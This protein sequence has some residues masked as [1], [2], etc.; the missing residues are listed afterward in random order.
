D[1]YLLAIENIPGWWVF[2]DS[3]RPFIEST[4]TDLETRNPGLEVRTHWITKSSFGRN[5]VYRPY[6]NETSDSLATIPNAYFYPGR[7]PSGSASSYYYVP[8]NIHGRMSRD[9]VETGGWDANSNPHPYA[10]CDFFNHAMRLP[11]EQEL[12]QAR[13]DAITAREQEIATAIAAGTPVPDPLDD[14]SKEPT[15]RLFLE[16]LNNN[17]DKY[18]NALVINLHGE[19]LPMP[20]LRNYSDA[21]RDPAVMPEVRVVSHPEQLHTFRDPSGTATEAAAFRVYAYNTDTDNYSGSS[22]VP[23]IAIDVMGMDVTDPTTPALDVRSD[24]RLE[25]LRGGISVGGD[26][27]YYPFAQA[28]VYGDPTLEPGEMCYAAVPMS[29]SAFVNGEVFT[30]IFLFNTPCVAPYVS[31]RGLRNTERSQLYGMSY[32]PSPCGSGGDFSRDLYSTGSAPKNTARWRLEL[33]ATSFQDALFMNQ[34]GQYYT[35][36][37]YVLQLRTRIWTSTDAENSGTMWPPAQRN[38]PENLSRTYTWWVDSPNDVP[39]TERSQFFGDPRHMPYLDLQDGDPD[40]PNGYNWYWDSLANGGEDAVGDFPGLNS[41]NTR[42]GWLGRVTF[43]A[44]RMLKLVRDGLVKSRCVYTTLT[45][46]SY[47]YLGV[48]AEIGYDAANGYPNS[49][50]VDQTPYGSSGSGFVNNITGPRTMPRG[51]NGGSDFWWAMPWLGE[52]SPDS[53]Y[54]THWLATDSTGAVMGNLPAGSSGSE[55]RHEVTETI[56][57]ASSR[58]AYGTRLPQTLHRLRE[59]GC[60]SLFNTGTQSSTFHHQYSS[61]IG[62]LTQTGQEIASNYNFNMPDLTPISRPFGMNTSGSG[63]VGSEWS[64]APY[65]NER[66]ITNLLRQYY[67]HP[68]GNNGS[69][70]V[71]LTDPGDTRSSFIVV[72][73]IDRTVQTGSSFIAKFA[74]LSLVHS[75]FEG[76]GSAAR[77]RIKQPARIEITSPTDITELVSPAQIDVTVNVEWTRWD[78]LPYTTNGGLAEDETELEYVLLYSRDGGATWLH[79]RDDSPATPGQRPTNPFLIEPD[80][81]S[82]PETF[83]WNSPASSYPQG[84]YYLRV[85]CFRSG[86]QIHYSYHKT[87]LF[88]QR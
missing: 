19:L 16:D 51:N 14:M 7:M 45:G 8:Q 10:L 20:A 81:G 87:K 71:E 52:L 32:I 49:I 28:K 44:P 6:T 60:T 64:L 27:S 62:A 83:S 74:V 2:M 70:L 25:N 66:S 29:F 85:D 18:S 4:I 22:T 73:G 13:V 67:D 38:A 43:D 1:L 50:P 39:V 57:T 23:V 58:K 75:F 37:D 59:E 80:T 54:L 30:R 68:N 65:S 76:G 24:V 48:G 40:W 36:E 34:L 26:S 15:L 63:S 11:E 9:G 12:W 47:Y 56:H 88:I 21:A 35:P 55:F 69:G 46:F 53:H 82:G 17:P 3:I 86:A 33:P 77:H 79:L 42:N 5:P 72:N 31:N 84:S 78:G 61:G 41:Q